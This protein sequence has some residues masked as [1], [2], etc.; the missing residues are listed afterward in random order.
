MTNEEDWL[1]RA[2]NRNELD[3]DERGSGSKRVEVD[4]GG[5][6]GKAG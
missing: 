6:L 1:L 3:K 5:I 2:G 4:S